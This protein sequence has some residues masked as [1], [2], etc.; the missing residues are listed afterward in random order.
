MSVRSL[1]VEY[2]SSVC[3]VDIFNWKASNGEFQEW[4]V[5]HTILLTAVRLHR[6][7]IEYIHY[8]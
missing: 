7:Y 2:L 1:E 8:Q 6:T 3:K 4:P 5:F